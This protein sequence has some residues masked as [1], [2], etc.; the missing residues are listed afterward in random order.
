MMAHLMKAVSDRLRAQL[1]TLYLLLTISSTTID[2]V[3][4]NTYIKLAMKYVIYALP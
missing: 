2:N 4:Y 1:R 3:S